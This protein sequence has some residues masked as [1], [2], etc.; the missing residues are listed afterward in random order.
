MAGPGALALQTQP[1]E[2]RQGRRS[3][4]EVQAMHLQQLKTAVHQSMPEQ[5][6]EAA[7]VTLWAPV[8]DARLELQQ[9]C[10]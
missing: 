2:G 10:I 4:L 5:T 7:L 3:R 8:S 6:L 9:V 1:V